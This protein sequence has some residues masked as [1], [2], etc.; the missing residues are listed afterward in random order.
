MT[1]HLF[2]KTRNI[3]VQVGLKKWQSGLTTCQKNQ[4]SPT[5]LWHVDREKTSAASSDSRL[6]LCAA[7]LSH[8]LV[9]GEFHYLEP[10]CILQKLSV[11][12]QVLFS[13]IKCKKN[14]Q[15]NQK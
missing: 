4:T 13:L 1:L 10:L 15:Q 2:Q 11:R 5:S 12:K 8:L 6:I 14:K 7:A 3:Y 9:L